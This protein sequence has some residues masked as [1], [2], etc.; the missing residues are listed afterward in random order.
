MENTKQGL[1]M[2]IAIVIAGAL[3]AGA[4]YMT[5]GSNSSRNTADVASGTADKLVAVDLK[6]DH[7]FGDPNAKVIILEYSDIEC[8]YCKKFHETMQRIVAEYKGDVAWVYRHLPLHKNAPREAEATECAFDQKSNDGFW[9]YL[10]AIYKATP[11]ND[12]LADSEL[13]KIAASIGL[14]VTKFT[15]CLD[16]SKFEAKVTTQANEA[17]TAGARGTPFNFIIVG[18]DKVELRGALPYE[19]LK[20]IIDQSLK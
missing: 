6:N 19:N 3:I 20:T 10:N 12:G 15:Q 17:R 11:S 16:S 2:P 9:K 1:G 8:P 7:I 4:I 18:E 5:N 14:D 13:P